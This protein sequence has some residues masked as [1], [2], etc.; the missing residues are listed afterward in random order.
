VQEG[1]DHSPH[2]KA[3]A[4]TLR[5]LEA[6]V[7]LTPRETDRLTIFTLAELARRHRARGIKLN[8]PESVA[9]ICDEMLEEARAGRSYDEVLEHGRSVLRRT[10]VMDGVPEMIPTVQ[11]EAMFADGTKLLTLHQPIGDT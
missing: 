11:V 3:E 9:L 10:D 2:S 7:R 4:G 1:G 6:P 5:R 8:H